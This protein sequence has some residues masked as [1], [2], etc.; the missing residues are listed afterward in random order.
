MRYDFNIDLICTPNSWMRVSQHKKMMERNDRESIVLSKG[1][2]I[3]TL[4]VMIA[5]KKTPNIK[6][7]SRNDTVEQIIIQIVKYKM[8]HQNVWETLLGFIELL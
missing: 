1:I 8:D 7:H 2:D 5:M 4:N 6:Q 3:Q